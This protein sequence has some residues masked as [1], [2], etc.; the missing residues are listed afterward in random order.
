[1][2]PKTSA[3]PPRLIERL[4]RA[5]R[6]RHYSPNTE[7]T[8]VRWVLQYIRFHG[9]QHPATLSAVEI[10][11]FLTYLA[12]ERRVSASTQNQ[13]LCALLFL[14]REV[15]NVENIELDGIV[16]AKIPQRLPTVLNHGEVERLLA[17]L[18]GVPWL[19]ASLLY[20][21]GMR[22]MEC[23]ELRIKDVDFTRRQI[24]I[25]SGKGDKDRVTLLPRSLVEP[26]SRQ[27][28]RAETVHRQDLEDGAGR[29][30]LPGSL[31]RKY[32]NCDREL[33]W[34]WIFP[35]TRRYVESETGIVRR[36]HVHPT[37]VQR[38]VKEAAGL[39]RLPRRVGCHALRHSFATQLLEAGYDIR[40]IQ[41][42]LGHKD[43]KTTMIYT[44]VL[45]RG[46]LGV[47]SPLDEL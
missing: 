5:I 2:K 17:N 38:A 4:R 47:R 16:R 22:L 31:H 34:Q 33:G 13:A 11:R 44:H 21:S 32:P 18:K 23:L 28:R 27:I 37:V 40:T 8:Y 20:G 30:V 6:V 7:K 12:V 15:L 35:A 36:H 46:G 29:V 39:A 25:R 10:S 41:E 14:Y 24:V 45:N 26:V 1:M 3:E 19:V 9:R 43:V 42:L